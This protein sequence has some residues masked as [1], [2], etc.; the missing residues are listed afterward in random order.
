MSEKCIFCKMI[1]REMQAKIVFE[2]N[3]IIAIEDINPQAPVHLLLIPKKHIST[4][5]EIEKE[6]SEILSAVFQSAKHLAKEKQIDES[7][8]RIVLNCNEGAGQSVFHIHFH[9]LGGR[10]MTWP[11][12]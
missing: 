9:L 2:D 4:T 12:G 1:R 8:F 6:D 3:T 5:M 11:P 7:G 10:Q